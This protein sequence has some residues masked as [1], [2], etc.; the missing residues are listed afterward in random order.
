M[1]SAEIC[2]FIQQTRVETGPNLMHQPHAPEQIET[3]EHEN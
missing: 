3:D 1:V 2:I